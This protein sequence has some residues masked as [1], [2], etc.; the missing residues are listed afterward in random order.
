MPYFGTTSKLRLT[1]CVAPIRDVMNEAIKFIDFTVVYG[2]RT[3]EEQTKAYEEGNSQVP[4][5]ESTHNTQPL[6]EGIDI[7]PWPIDWNDRE[8]FTLL[9]GVVLGM[10]Y[11]MGIELRWG[12]DWDRDTQVKDNKFDDLGHF[13][14]VGMLDIYDRL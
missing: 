13:E 10:A 2:Q 9:A 5:P 3:E 11:H 6:S 7:A 8:R 1:T 4:W 14:Y 12:G